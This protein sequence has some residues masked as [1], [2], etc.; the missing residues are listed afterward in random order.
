ME[1]RALEIDGYAGLYDITDD[2][3]IFSV[4][5]QRFLKP[6]LNSSGYAMYTLTPH[7]GFVPDKVWHMAHRLV[8]MHF[9]GDP[10]TRWH[11]DCHHI[12]HD[13][14][15]NHYSN[16]EW[17][18]H[19]EN[20]LRSW[21]ETDRVSPWAGKKR[22]PHSP[23]TIA[24]MSTAKE[25]GAY[26]EIGGDCKEYRSVRELLDDLGIYRKAFNRAI[27]SGIPYKGMMFGFL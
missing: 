10:P 3:Q 23:E 11:T 21:R 25:K 7:K 18:T 17:L 4:R 20:L 12:D 26:V 6:A 13:K 5:K 27:N 14:T 1:K 22:G 15:N 8:A 19:S 16:L 2:G 24:K 9:I